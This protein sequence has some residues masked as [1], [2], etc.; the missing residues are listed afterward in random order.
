MNAYQ[1]FTLLFDALDYVYDQAPN[2]VL[3]NYLS[4]L[5]PD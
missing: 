5:N 3:G 1:L 2:E 4:G